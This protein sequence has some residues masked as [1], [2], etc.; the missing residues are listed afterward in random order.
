MRLVGWAQLAGG[1][2]QYQSKQLDVSCGQSGA[3]EVLCF[4]LFGRVGS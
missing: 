3:V 4:Y 1:G 2:P